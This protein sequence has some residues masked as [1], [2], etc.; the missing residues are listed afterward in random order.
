MDLFSLQGQIVY[1]AG[2]FGDGEGE[3]VAELPYHI[4]DDKL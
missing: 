2:A 4:G 1:P 3:I